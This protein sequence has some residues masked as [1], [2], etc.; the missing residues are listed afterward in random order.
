[1]YHF[2]EPAVAETFWGI[3]LD[4][5]MLAFRV[6]VFSLVGVW[7]PATAMSMSSRIDWVFVIMSVA[8]RLTAI[9]CQG[10]GS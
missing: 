1:M 4:G 2:W 6:R 9:T 3:G 7:S 5:G 8:P 10:K